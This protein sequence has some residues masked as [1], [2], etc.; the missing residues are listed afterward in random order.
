MGILRTAAGALLD[1]AEIA[2]PILA[3]E[4]AE[5]NPS[6]FNTAFDP[7]ALP[8]VDPGAPAPSVAARPLVAEESRAS[9]APGQAEVK[10]EP[11]T[12]DKVG[13][14]A[15]VETT[16]R[17]DAPA[18][19][20]STT[21]VDPSQTEAREGQEVV[22]KKKRR[23]HRSGQ[24]GK[25]KEKSRKR[26]REASPKPSQAREVEPPTRTPPV[27][28]PALGLQP[29]PKPAA[30]RASRLAR[31]PTPPPAPARPGPVEPDHPPPSRRGPREGR[32]PH[33]RGRSPNRRPRGTK[34]VQH[35][36]RGIYYGYS[37]R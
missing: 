1:L 25:K 16:R 30:T 14:L 24:E 23:K 3:R 37:R 31:L 17:D 27:G 36:L 15:E 5:A 35:R 18:E 2:A 29:A 34:G 20:G 8:P 32:E 12:E 22:K 13:P 6:G 10:A 21:A 33:S 26:R 28:T 11:E 19:G 4:R 7:A 9:K